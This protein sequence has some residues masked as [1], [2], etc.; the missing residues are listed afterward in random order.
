VIC[1]LPPA[2]L[3]L[4]SFGHATFQISN[5]G[6]ISVTVHLIQSSCLQAENQQ[7]PEANF[8]MAA[9]GTVNPGLVLSCDGPCDT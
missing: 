2:G 9:S 6:E 4:R 7:H 1:S 8:L 3:L 5:F